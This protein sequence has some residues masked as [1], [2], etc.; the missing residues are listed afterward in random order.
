MEMVVRQWGVYRTLYSLPGIKVK[1]LLVLPSKKLSMQKHYLRN[2]FW[3]VSE[4]IAT[5]KREN[6][7]Y[8]VLD[9]HHHLFIKKQ[10]WHQLSNETENDLRI[11]EIQ[12]GDDCIE[13][14][15]E[16]I[17]YDSSK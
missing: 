4:G 14:D 13:L 6:G 8:T 10:E 7:S 17:N 15:I 11:V 3:M 16:R 12:Y 1:E 2:E 9:K 5:V